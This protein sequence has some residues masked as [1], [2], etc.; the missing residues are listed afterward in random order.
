MQRLKL[1]PPLPQLLQLQPVL[2]K[3]QPHVRAVLMELFGALMSYSFT[4]ACSFSLHP[5]A[6]SLALLLSESRRSVRSFGT[7]WT[8][9]LATIGDALVGVPNL[10][11]TAPTPQV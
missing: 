7:R 2:D 5:R 1:N 8:A 11:Q 6:I 10:G 9:K 4:S 3:T